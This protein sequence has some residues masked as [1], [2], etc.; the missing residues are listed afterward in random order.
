MES[1]K[2]L[3][4]YVLCQS[5][6]HY[7]HENLTVGHV[8]MTLENNLSLLLDILSVKSKLQW[9]QGCLHCFTLNTAIRQTARYNQQINVMLGGGN[10]LSV[11]SL[12]LLVWNAQLS[13]SWWGYCALGF[14]SSNGRR[15][16]FQGQLTPFIGCLRFW[17][18]TA[19]GIPG[20]SHRFFC[21]Q[22]CCSKQ[23]T[24]SIPSWN[25][26]TTAQNPPTLKV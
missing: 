7:L 15:K 16:L 8:Q 4:S 2:H 5:T 23:R 10:V 24:T 12:F 25:I 20:I 9:H 1:K 6:L 3:F 13:V 18:A 26:H 11:F 17:D 14:N 21:H 22:G 19:S